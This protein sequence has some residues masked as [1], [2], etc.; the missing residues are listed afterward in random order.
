MENRRKLAIATLCRSYLNVHGFITP[1]E[2]RRVFDR[3][4]KWANKNKISISEAQLDSA[5]FIYDDSAKEEEGYN[6]EK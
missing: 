5:D 1:E 6:N 3:I 2:N 4:L